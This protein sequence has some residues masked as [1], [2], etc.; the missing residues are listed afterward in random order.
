MATVRHDLRQGIRSLRR[1]W[2]VNAVAAISLALALA[3]NT[4]VF[5]LVNAILFRP[6]P[7]PSPDRIVIMGDREAGAPQ[8]L[9]TSP[10]NFVDWAERN[11]AFGQLAGFRP[12]QATIGTGERPVM[13]PSAHVSPS[14]F[15][16]LGASTVSGRT[17]LPE[18]GEIGR[19]RVALVT[20][21]LLATHLPDLTDPI[22]AEVRIN[23]EPHTIVG[24]LPSDFEFFYP[25]LQIWLP[26]ALDPARLSRD[27]RS[28]MVVGRLGDGVTMEQAREDMQRVLDELTLEYPESNRG[29]VV[30]V[31]NLRHEIPTPQ[32]RAL[33]ALLQGAVVF[34]LLIACVN[35][36]NLL[37]ARGQ[38]RRREVALRVI[39]GAG[40]WHIVRQLLIESL[41]LAAAAGLVGLGLAYASVRIIG[42]QFAGVVAGMYMPAIDPPVLI[43]TIAMTVFA[44]LLFGILPAFQSFRVDL[45]GTV[46]DGGRGVAGAAGKKLLSRGLVVAEIGLS[47]VLLGGASVM[48]QGF[49]ELRESDPG[50]DDTQ[51]LTVPITLPVDDPDSR[52]SLL[53]EIEQRAESV[54][55]V[56][57]V[58]TTSSLPLNVVTLSDAFTIEGRPVAPDQARPR[59]LWLITP[60]DYLETL[61]IP[62]VRGRFFSPADRS[63]ATSVVVVNEALARLH[64]PEE[65]AIGQRIVFRDASREIVG[66]VG[67]T[68]QSLIAVSGLGADGVDPMIYLPLAQQAPGTVFLLVRTSV[69]PQSVSTVLRNGLQQ[70]HA[71]LVVGRMQTLEETVDQLF[72]GI[73]LFSRILTAFGCLALLL[74]AIGTYGVLAYNVSQRSQEIGV[75]MAVGAQRR[76][77]IQM[78]TRQGVMLGVIGL[79]LGTPFLFILARV[80]D[81]AFQNMAEIQIGNM[82][83]VGLVLLASTAIA[84]LLPALRASRLDPVKV[85]GDE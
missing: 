85:L 20:D 67:N 36:A 10:A 18:E 48:V 34:V 14:F 39:L 45:A 81:F 16:I 73:N 41:M 15:D 63:D 12:G 56:L 21:D 13:T 38:S 23:G 82:I 46:K 26:L 32:G 58:T 54:P 80:L 4:T 6:L 9:T 62:L 22:G 50:F 66:V 55:G 17:F 8:T 1:E 19:H 60:P 74:A 25:N 52:L 3:G 65:D 76:D 42:R 27:E 83:V 84:S 79:A 11:R 28:V 35:I 59:G 78:I 47:L 53:A 49:L 40:R 7:Y 75:R 30:D 37:S 44:G 69:E 68:R 51:L 5:S 33:F 71:Q 72:V 29:N 77:V 31:L 24:V 61:G 64:W 70:I 2:M 43:F 57:E